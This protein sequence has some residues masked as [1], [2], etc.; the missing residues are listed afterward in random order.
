MVC[1]L[2][3]DW[4]TPETLTVGCLLVLVITQGLFDTKHLPTAK[5]AFEGFGKESLINAG[6]LFVTGLMQTGAMNLLA[7]PFL[8][9]PRT[10]FT[11]QLRLLVPVTTLSEFLN[12]TPI[13][14]MFMPVVDD[15]CKKTKISPPKLFL[16]MAYAA[17]FGG[18]CSMIG[19]ST[20]LVV[21]GPCPRLTFPHSACSTSPGLVSRAPSEESFTY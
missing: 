21:K 6:V 17:T 11:A 12:N 15:I 18:V 1:A 20:N 13:V 9:R 2:A 7:E 14:A 8:G 16:P 19:T 5:Q 10:V 4:S 3:R